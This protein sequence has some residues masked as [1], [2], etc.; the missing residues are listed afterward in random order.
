MAQQYRL[1]QYLRLRY[2]NFISS[3][4]SPFEVYYRSSDFN[5][6]LE[7]AQCNAAGFFSLKNNSQFVKGLNWRPIPIHS[8]PINLDRVS[9]LIFFFALI[10]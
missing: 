1:G 4:Y 3:N 10:K 9:N 2:D 5:R 6:T 7:S 8:L